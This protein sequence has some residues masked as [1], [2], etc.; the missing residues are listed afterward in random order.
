MSALPEI[1]ESDLSIA[2][3]RG[4][5]P[6]GQNV[7]KVATTAQLRFDVAGTALLDDAARARLRA[8]A[9][10]RLTAEGE[11]LIVARNH[12]TQEGN[13][14]EALGRLRELLGRALQPPKLRRPTR[15]SRASKERRLAGK[16]HRQRN[17]QLRR[18][19]RPDD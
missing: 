2:F 17:K 3:V 8:L 19:V 6:G 4:T 16:L 14:R 18:A 1:P 5:G 11:L 15:P 12:R 9:G 13:R 10:H 7:N